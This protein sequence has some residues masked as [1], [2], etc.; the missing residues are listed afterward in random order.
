MI[1]RSQKTIGRK[2][3]T[4]LTKYWVYLAFQNGML[5]DFLALQQKVLIKVGI[6][7]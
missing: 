3:Y 1:V 7:S 4:S 6:V 5:P 2:G